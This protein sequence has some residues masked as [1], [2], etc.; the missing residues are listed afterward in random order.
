[1]KIHH[2]LGGP[3]IILTNEEKDF[4]NKHHH[5]IVI[6]TLYDRDEVLA[7]NLVRKGVY[8]ISTDNE[9]IILKKDAQS[10]PTLI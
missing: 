10:K 2:L 5:D 9:R 1:M 4:I 6:R 7:R 3:S 8:D